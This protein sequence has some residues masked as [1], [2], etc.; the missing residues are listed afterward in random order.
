MMFQRVGIV[1]L[2]GLGLAVAE[3]RALWGYWISRPSLCRELQAG[4]PISGFSML[5]FSPI[6]EV[7]GVMDRRAAHEAASRFCEPETNEC[8]EGSLILCLKRQGVK[9]EA[10]PEVPLERYATVLLPSVVRQWEP[11]A[12]DLAYKQSSRPAH[13]VA[14]AFTRNSDQFLLIGYR[15]SEIANDSYAYG[16]ILYRI[17]GDRAAVVRRVRFL[18]DIA[19]V[20]GLEWPL[21]WPLN[22][23]AL[24]ALLVV[25]VRR[26]KRA[27]PNAR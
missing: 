5:R 14:I 26:R 20:E 1:A 15:T 21:L 6:G 4:D 9:L 19:G 12:T 16:E 11:E 18:L 10:V 2:V 22:A 13:G 8:R 17:E 23:A 24:F 3:N 27:S 25:G 7:A